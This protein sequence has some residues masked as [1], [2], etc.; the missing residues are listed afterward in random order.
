MS[1]IKAPQAAVSAAILGM[2]CYG[3]GTESNADAVLVPGRQLFAAVSNT[4]APLA[5]S[6]APD[7]S[8]VLAS[9]A[10]L[11]QAAASTSNT[12]TQGVAGTLFHACH[13]GA[14]VGTVFQSDCDLLLRG[15]TQDP[16]GVAQALSVL[17]PDQVLAP[18]NESVQQV[19]AGLGVVS[20]RLEGLR[21]AARD[22]VSVTSLAAQML[23]Q[24]TGG[25]AS[26]DLDLGRGGL[27]FNLKYLDT[28][29]DRN[30]YTSGY[31]QDGLRLTLGAD[32]RVQ[33]NLILGLFANYASADTSYWLNKGGM[34]TTTWGLGLYGTYYWDNGS[35]IEGSLGYDTHDYDLTRRLDYSIV[36][37]GVRTQVRQL[38]ISDPDGRTFYASLG[39]GYNLDVQAFTLMP[40]LKFNYL[41]NHLD[42][43]HERISDPSA[44]GGGMGL[45]FDSQTYESFT[46]RLGF[47]IARAFSSGVGVWVPQLSLDWVHEFSADQKQLAARFVN[48]L[49]ATPLALTT[50]S[51]DRNYFDLGIGLAGQF[52]QGRSAFISINK[53]LGYEDIEH[54]SITGGVRMEF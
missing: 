37:D 17:T 4:A 21:S 20:M 9:G 2:A 30:R 3:Q 12:N 35:F 15:A 54:Y 6:T 52:A 36:V 16:A 34:D 26:A 44:P 10:A 39:G 50:S 27:F 51:P 40:S 7:E 32:Y 1:R 24:A 43:Y 49:S 42:S 22:Q 46:S 38:A 23:R 48:D 5:T 53:L 19:S 25:G 11:D 14:N 33:D 47:T 45:A 18:R 31:D 29:Q 41:R 13:S 8:T 28:E